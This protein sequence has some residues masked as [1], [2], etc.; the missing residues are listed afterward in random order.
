M[1]KHAYSNSTHSPSYYA[2]SANDTKG[3]PALSGDIEV[4]VA[5]IGAGF[6][7]VA[8]ALSL[9]EAGYKVAI[10]EQHK[11][12]WG[13]SG[14]DG[15]HITGSLSGAQ[16]MAKE[17]YKTLGDETN[18][19]IWKLRWRGHEIINRRVAEY[20][21]ECDLKNG[22][23]QT[24]MKPAHID[25][26][27]IWEAEV[28][29]RG[30]GD[31]LTWVGPT[32]MPKY[33]E[34]E[35]YCG[36]LLNRRNMH[37]HTLNLVLGEARAAQKIGAQIFE[38]T[39]VKQITHGDTP[40]LICD[41]GNISAKY[42]VLAGNAYHT[43]EQSS[44][45]GIILPLVLG[46]MTSVQLGEELAQQLNPKNLAI[47]D[48]R[49]VL[50]YF[51]MTADHRL[52]FGGGTNV[53]KFQTSNI[54]GKLRSA[55]ERTFPRLKGIQIEFEWT[56]V[57]GAVPNFIPQVGRLSQN[58]LFAQGYSGHGLA[59][60]HVMGEILASAIGGD[61]IGFDTL[62]NVSHK[63]IPFARGLADVWGALGIAYYQM[64]ES[65]R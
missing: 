17:F 25:D 33:L 48:S 54:E 42:V 45:R 41:H 59:L 23:M 18:D 13:A 21:I 52:M 38:H 34:T 6:T 58:V 19:F 37:V 31:D 29:D 30:M 47:Y 65:R 5:I 57:E 46:N 49:A 43:L 24:A 35:L 39:A 11:V 22:H 1:G 28:N 27:R 12:G 8:T 56:G 53:Q 2:A 36:G 4:D 62:A 44:L 40:R 16:F 15:G 51:R 32:D 26:L 61:T 60:S 55:M 64:L 3:F 10:A 9:A 14:R 20:G 63:K 7:G 50:N